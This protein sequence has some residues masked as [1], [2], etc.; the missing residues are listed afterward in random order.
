MSVT[1]LQIGM[2]EP[3]SSEGRPQG[4]S[5]I[6]KRA[7]LVYTGT[8][9]SMDGEVS[10]K[11]EDLTRL[12]QN[13]NQ[14]LGNLK[15]NLSGDLP[16][17]HYPPVQV[18]HS[19]SAWD[20]VGRLVGDIEVGEH[21]DGSGTKHMAL[22]S[23]LRIL[24]KDNVERVQDGRWTNLSIGADF[25]SGKITE[26]TITPF[27]AAPEAAMLSTRMAKSHRKRLD[28]V[29]AQ[30]SL[31]PDKVKE[32]TLGDRKM[33]LAYFHAMGD[34]EK[35][36]TLLSNDPMFYDVKTEKEGESVYY[37]CAY[38]S[39][40]SVPKAKG[41]ELKKRRSQQMSAIKKVFDKLLGRKPETVE[42]LKARH[43]SEA[44]SVY[45]LAEAEEKDKAPGSYAM[46]M[47]D[48]MKRH[49]DEMDM[50]LEGKPDDEKESLKKGYM[51]EMEALAKKH[52]ESL[53]ARME[54]PKKKEDEEKKMTAS[55]ESLTRL[56]A[57][58]R[59]KSDEVKLEAKKANLLVRLSK[60]KSEAKITPAEIKKV[61]ID[62]LSKESEATVEAVFK[63]YESREPVII[64][65]F[66]GTTKGLNISQMQ[67]LAEKNAL[68]MESRM[69]MPL[70]AADV[71]KLA[72]GKD[73][74]DEE[75]KMAGAV[76]QAQYRQHLD[77]LKKLMDEGKVEEA[78]MALAKLMESAPSDEAV[79]VD[80]Q[81]K[82]ST[83][84][85]DCEKLHNKFEEVIGVAAKAVG[86]EK[87]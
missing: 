12:S 86:A 77:A 40:V 55:R 50:A 24:G 73:Q 7:L 28:E 58:F 63:S 6:E 11:D 8:F 75:E 59:A 38:V 17:K 53:R 21:V 19:D 85:E 3:D 42:E 18:N 64:P 10:V 16:L 65:G 13:H 45:R 44:E 15:K 52:L 54:E 9:L 60:L 31:V 67:R 68:E 46:K 32:E 37:V 23:R 5:M 35:L 14:M 34:A 82:L 36:A 25:N 62:R 20:T 48:T 71:K 70:K 39:D 74:K 84:A 26:L 56:A 41:A 43:K 61:D 78:K 2:I 30:N 69:N 76:S 22:Y 72:E 57:E 80:M 47:E 79:G 51:D 66:V 33:L 1:R 83:L 49:L 4:A 87:I 29:A 81:K 27:P